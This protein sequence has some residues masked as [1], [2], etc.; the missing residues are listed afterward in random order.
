MPYPEPLVAPMRQEL[1]QLGFREMRTA[2]EVETILDGVSD[3][4][5]VVVNSVCGCAAGAMRP[6]VA[7]SLRD[8]PVPAAL[9]TVFAGQDVDATARAREYFA[10]Y[11]PSSPAVA[12]LKDGELVWMM[13]RHEIEGRGPEQIAQH[14][15]AAYRE[16]CDTGTPA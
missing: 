3:P 12:L 8:N 2:D 10:G 7:L 9:T 13:E 5:L 11:P 1:V 15:Q 6:G 16:H 4:V 14:L